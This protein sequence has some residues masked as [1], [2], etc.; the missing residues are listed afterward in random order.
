MFVFTRVVGLH[1]AKRYV[2]DGDESRLKLS[3]L[4]TPGGQTVC[5]RRSGM[6]NFMIKYFVKYQVVQ[7][8]TMCKAIHWAIR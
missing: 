1:E 2:V 4:Q 7:A 5:Y 3:V 6:K 8:L